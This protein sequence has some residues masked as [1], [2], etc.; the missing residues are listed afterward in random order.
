MS[1]ENVGKPSFVYVL[2]KAQNKEVVVIN[3]GG[4]CRLPGGEIQDDEKPWKA[5]E[6]YW[7][8]QTGDTFAGLSGCSEPIH[9]EEKGDKTI[10]YYAGEDLQHIMA[11][12]KSR[13]RNSAEIGSNDNESALST[14]PFNALLVRDGFSW[15]KNVDEKYLT[16]ETVSQLFYETFRD[17]LYGNASI[18]DVK[19]LI[20]QGADVNYANNEN[21]DLPI[22]I[23]ARFG[24]EPLL[25]LL[26]EHGA[27]LNKMTNRNDKS[28]SALMDAIQEQQV[29]CF[30]ILIENGADVRTQDNNQNNLIHFLF[31]NSRNTDDIG[32][33]KALIESGLDVNHKNKYGFTPL[34]FA[35]QQPSK[36]RI[37]S[38]Y[39]L[40]DNGAD[41]YATT[42][43]GQ[44]L[45]DFVPET[46][47]GE[48]LHAAI[49]S[50]EESKNL[51][52]V[53]CVEH[54]HFNDSFPKF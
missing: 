36:N 45:F 15:L 6:K 8:D 7:R 20:H 23:A 26:I 42:N 2:G 38:V 22:V 37:E 43:N 29:T 51:S 53:I 54:S 16:G 3:E 13:K 18:D 11:I 39:M 21:G 30:D 25:R 46:E 50:Y 17:A 4:A 28:S 9:T 24:N 12:K 10:F 47:K 49:K 32:L 31:F 35:V 48:E 5:A 27:D 44:T 33:L 34:M 40:L 52:S 1:K 14:M 41:L 19:A